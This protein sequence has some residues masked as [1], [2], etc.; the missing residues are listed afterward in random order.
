MMQAQRYPKNYDGILSAAPAI[1]WASFV[2]AEM[3]GHVLMKKEK[4]YPPACEMEALRHAAI[5]ACDELD[6]VKDGV[7]AAH[8]QC[9]FDA[10]TV[11]G[12]KFDCN[13]DIRKISKSAAK[14]ANAVWRGPERHGKQ[15]WFGISH[16]ASLVGG[17]LGGLVG[18]QPATTKAKTARALLFS[19]AKAGSSTS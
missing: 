19:S 2:V 15:G 1:N 4:Y 8:H 9:R 16:E 18:P 13:G 3:W 10:S 14:I 5:E 12:Q 11:V 6:G 17:M 7:I